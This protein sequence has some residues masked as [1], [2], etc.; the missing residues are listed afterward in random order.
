MKKMRNTLS[1]CR[2]CQ[3]QV[4]AER[5]VHASSRLCVCLPTHK[6]ATT[7]HDCGS[8]RG[9][10]SDKVRNCVYIL[11]CLDRAAEWKRLRCRR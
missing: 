11:P 9:D 6:A 4:N 7:T 5:Q 8:Y 10:G 2:L 1:L 3:F